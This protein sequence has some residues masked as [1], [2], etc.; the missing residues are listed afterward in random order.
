[1]ERNN[2]ASIEGEN[3][4][5][6]YSRRER[7]M[8]QGHGGKWSSWNKDLA[9]SLAY[10]SNVMDVLD[11][12]NM[13]WHYLVMKNAPIHTPVRVR[14]L[15]ESRGYQCVYLPPYSPFLNPIEEFCSKVKA[16][17]RRNA[18]TVDDRLSYRICES[19]Q[20]VTPSSLSSTDSSCGVILSKVQAKR[21]QPVRREDGLFRQ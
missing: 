10:I 18:L 15:V 2:I 4:I 7:Q 17:V 1:M 5:Y 13:K 14:V 9:F 19:V 6:Q 16:G 21:Y 8:T 12:N 11:R 3:M 20:M